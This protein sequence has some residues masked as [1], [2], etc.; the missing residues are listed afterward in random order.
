L[1]VGLARNEK[2]ESARSRLTTPEGY[3]LTAMTAVDIAK[4]V[5]SGDFKPGFQTPSLAY[6]ADY[7]LGFDG[8]T[9]EELN[10]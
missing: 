6:G 1:L 8:V 4:R 7:I 10:A 9:R 2:G 5:A 3:T